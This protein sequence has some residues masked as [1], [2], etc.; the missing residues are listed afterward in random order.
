MLLFIES[1]WYFSIYKG[2]E[3]SLNSYYWMRKVFLKSMHNLKT[4]FFCGSLCNDY[5]RCPVNYWFSKQLSFKTEKTELI[6]ILFLSHAFEYRNQL[7]IF[8]RKT[9]IVINQ[10]LNNKGKCSINYPEVHGWFQIR[11][12]EKKPMKYNLGLRVNTAIVQ[13]FLSLLHP[14]F[15]RLKS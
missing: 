7:L 12:R 8:G 1:I 13:M 10:C 15:H 3:F 14:W 2:S 11:I 6:C 5:Y 9:N 4:D